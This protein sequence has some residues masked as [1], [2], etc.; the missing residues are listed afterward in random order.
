[1]R[2]FLYGLCIIHC[3]IPSL[4]NMFMKGGTKYISDYGTIYLT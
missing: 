2:S 1:M 4:R 3:I